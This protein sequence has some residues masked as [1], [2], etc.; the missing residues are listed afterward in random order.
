MLAHGAL[1][2]QSQLRSFPFLFQRN[3]FIVMEKVGAGKLHPVSLHG[4]IPEVLSG[5]IPSKFHHGLSLEQRQLAM[6]VELLQKWVAV[7]F[8]TAEYLL[9]RS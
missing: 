6:N 9:A 4:S 5:Y 8:Q 3:G 2:S 7:T 1:L